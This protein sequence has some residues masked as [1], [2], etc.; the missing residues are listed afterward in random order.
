MTSLSQLSGIKSKSTDTTKTAT[1][2]PLV[3]KFEAKEG[4]QEETKAKVNKRKKVA[5]KPVTVNIKINK[6]QKD[7]LANTASQ[8]RDNN[9]EPV[10]PADRVYPQ[11]L[12]GVAIDL[13]KNADVDWGEVRNAEELRDKLNL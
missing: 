5:D 1:P 13:L 8:V 3:K 7:W 10:P 2:E 9:T 11:H 4:K 12:I 6:N